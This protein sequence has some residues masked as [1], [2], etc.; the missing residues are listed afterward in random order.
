MSAGV[1]AGVKSRSTR[2]E[3]VGGKKIPTNQSVSG[4]LMYNA[5][6]SRLRKQDENATEIGK[7]ASRD[8]ALDG[9]SK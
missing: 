5:D 6:K 3:Y 7:G 8:S 9:N 4:T 2:V 1:V